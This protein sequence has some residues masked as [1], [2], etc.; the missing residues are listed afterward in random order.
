MW[1]SDVVRFAQRDG[2]AVIPLMKTSCEPTKWVGSMGT[3]ECG[4]WFAWAMRTARSLHPGAALIG[5]YY[6]WVG[7][8]DDP[9]LTASLDS[10]VSDLRRLSAHVVI[11]GDVPERDEQP[12]DCL[13]RPHAT[14]TGCSQPLGEA[15]PALTSLV[16]QLATTD[17]VA[18]VDP[19]GWFCS[20]GECPLVVGNLI[21]Y[22]DNNH[23][24]QVYATA[25]S[26]VMA[27]AVRR[28]V[29]GP[30]KRGS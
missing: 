25:L 12:V 6:S 30:A 19:T 23:I 11:I 26:A 9:K 8:G 20:E 15:Q 10:A 18:F 14:A 22:R 13:L 1:L 29:A 24:S 4:A 28:A 17:K 3:G 16:A 5:G 27:A 21:A 7:P 2:W